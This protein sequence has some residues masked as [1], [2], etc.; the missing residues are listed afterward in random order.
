MAAAKLTQ[1]AAE[2]QLHPDI[3]PEDCSELCGFFF[4]LQEGYPC[5]DFA[6]CLHLTYANSRSSLEELSSKDIGVDVPSFSMKQELLMSCHKT[7]PEKNWLIFIAVVY[8]GFIQ[9]K[10]YFMFWHFGQPLTYQW[11]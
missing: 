2:R 1:Q 11:Q 7:M 4:C 8:D 9:I 6:S 5:T 3:N 10:L